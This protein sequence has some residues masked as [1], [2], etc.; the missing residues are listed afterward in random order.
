[1]NKKALIDR[2]WHWFISMIVL[3]ITTFTILVGLQGWE[4]SLLDTPEMIDE[5]LIAYRLVNTPECLAVEEDGRIFSGEIDTQKLSESRIR[6]CLTETRPSYW[7][8]IRDSNENILEV[9]TDRMQRTRNPF[10]SYAVLES[11]ELVRVEVEI[12]R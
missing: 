12:R 9:S 5:R 3:I 2:S 7:I 11:G 6:R 8:R 1:M 4:D 10:V